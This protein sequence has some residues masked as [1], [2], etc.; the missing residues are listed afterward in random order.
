MVCWY[1]SFRRSGPGRFSYFSELR[2]PTMLIYYES[3]HPLDDL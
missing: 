1:D 3:P 2:V